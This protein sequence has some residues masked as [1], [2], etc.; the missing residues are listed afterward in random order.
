MV[1]CNGTIKGYQGAIEINRQ[2]NT[3]PVNCQWTIVVPKSNKVN[4]TFT[5]FK[6]VTRTLKALEKLQQLVNNT[7]SNTDLT[8]STNI[9]I[10]YILSNQNIL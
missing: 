4:I 7:C 3:I 5:S 8:V 9:T 1:D 6:I 10:M 2:E